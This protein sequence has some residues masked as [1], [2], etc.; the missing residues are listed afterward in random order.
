MP[1]A[2]VEAMPPAEVLVRYLS[3]YYHELRDE[4]FKATYLP[5]PQARPLT[6]RGGQAPEVRCPT[7]RR[8]DSPGCSCRPSRKVRLA[9]VRI[10]RKL[11]ALRAIEAL[12]MHAAAHGGELPDKLDQVTVVPVPERPG[13]RQAVRVPARGRD[14]HADQPHRRRAAEDD[15]PALPGDAAEVNGPTV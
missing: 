4:V 1:A 9:E 5:F 12:R 3:N 14:R 8:L 2:S 6:R 10:E 7:P 11:A 13:H 15:R